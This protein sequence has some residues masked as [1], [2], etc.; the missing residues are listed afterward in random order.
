MVLLFRLW[1]FFFELK[2]VINTDSGCKYKVEI[3]VDIDDDVCNIHTGYCSFDEFKKIDF[4][5]LDRHL[6]VQKAEY[7]RVYIPSGI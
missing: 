7:C 3:F 2:E 5:K 1:L 6:V 4:F